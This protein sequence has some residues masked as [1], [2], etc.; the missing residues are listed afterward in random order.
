QAVAGRA[1]GDRTWYDCLA[2]SMRVAQALVP[3]ECMA[4]P[5]TIPVPDACRDEWERWKSALAVTG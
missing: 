4:M 1:E 2:Q 3:F 5:T